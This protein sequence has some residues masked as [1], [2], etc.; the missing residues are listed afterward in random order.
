MKRIACCLSTLALVTACGDDSQGS[1]S[2]TA[3]ATGTATATATV[4]TATMGSASATTGT[5]SDSMGSVS[6]TGNSTSTTA[7]TMS[8][9]T[10]SGGTMSG[11]TMSGGTMSSGDTG[12]AGTVSGGDTGTA[13]TA[14]G[15]TMSGGT[16]AGASGGG[17]TG[18]N[19]EPCDVAMATLQPIPPNVMLVLDKS[20]S[21]VAQT[22]TRWSELYNVVDSVVNAFQDQIN[23]GAWL[24]PSVNATNDLNQNAC[25]VNGNPEVGVAPNNAAAILAGIPPANA[26]SATIKGGTPA[27]RAIDSAVNYLKGLNPENPRAI[28]LITDGAANCKIGTSWPEIFNDYDNSLHTFVANAWT[29]DGIPTHVVGID[30]DNANTGSQTDGTPDNINPWQKLDQLANEGGTCI[31]DCANGG[32]AD[33]YATTNQQ[34]L[35]D[36]LQAA[37]DSALSCVV[38]LNPEPPFP[39]LMEVEIGGMTVPKVNDCA[40]EDGWVYVNPNGPYDAVEICGTWCDQ[41]KMQGSLEAKYFCI[42]G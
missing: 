8:G 39:D 27:A 36:A 18:G 32:V 5:A 42:P 10:M 6:A 37:V 41:L 11:G 25:I 21:M 38:P 33:F 1:S 7:G 4:G 26:T 3:S 15:G 20:G 9:G 40:N 34:E 12:T 31:G 30:I 24:F 29:N 19:V 16:T 14:S 13:G 17:S 35:Q 28:I 23:F 22:P 2:F